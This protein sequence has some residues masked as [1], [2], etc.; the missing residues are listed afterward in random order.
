MLLSPSKD[1]TA[2][3][4]FDPALSVIATL[5]SRNVLYV[6]SALKCIVSL[7]FF[8]SSYVGSVNGMRSLAGSRFRR[9]FNQNARTLG[10]GVDKGHSLSSAEAPYGKLNDIG[11]GRARGERCEEGKGGNFSALFSL[12]GVPRALP[13]FPLLSLHQPTIK[14]ARK[15]PQRKKEQGS[16]C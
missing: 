5:V 2:V 7:H 3:H 8:C 13:F 10:G 9:I 15:R 1:E 14:A 6:V 11:S 4:F 16:R 12:P